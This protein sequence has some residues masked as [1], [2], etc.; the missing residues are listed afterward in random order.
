MSTRKE[1]EMSVTVSPQACMSAYK[2]ECVFSPLWVSTHVHCFVFHL[3]LVTW[4]ISSKG[5]WDAEEDSPEEAD[6]SI[7]SHENR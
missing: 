1:R 3:G 5:Q 4:K 7:S 2:S 6:G